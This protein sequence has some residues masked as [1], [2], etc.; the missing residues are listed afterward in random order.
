M[1]KGPVRL[2]KQVTNDDDDFY[3]FINSMNKVEGFILSHATLFLIIIVA[4]LIASFVVLMFAICG[5]SA[6]ESGAMR[7]FANR[8]MI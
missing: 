6:V 4:L 1:T 3:S 8:G 7:N 5:V 2:H